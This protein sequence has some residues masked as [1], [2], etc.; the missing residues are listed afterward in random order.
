MN[1]N[2][3]Q[4]YAVWVRN[5]LIEQ[6]SQHTYQYGISKKGYG[7]E[8]ATVISERVLSK[9][10]EIDLDNGVK[11]NYEIFADVLTGI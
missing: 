8:N 2:A 9:N 11:K 5:E 4:K 7:E 3:I 6:V 1:K 10:I